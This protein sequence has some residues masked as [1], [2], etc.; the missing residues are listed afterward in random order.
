MPIDVVCPQCRKTL[1][2]GD[3]VAGKKIRCPACQGVASVPDSQEPDRDDHDR[4]DD[5]KTRSV[6]ANREP[7]RRP[8]SEPS[9]ADE[10]PDD[11]FDSYGQDAAMPPNPRV[12]GRKS[13]DNPVK[14]SKANPLL[15]KHWIEAMS[16]SAIG[17]AWCGLMGLAA[18]FLV[19][20]SDVIDLD[21][22]KDFGFG[23]LVFSGTLLVATCIQIPKIIPLLYVSMILVGVIGAILSMSI[24]AGEWLMIVSSVACFISLHRLRSVI[25]L[26]H[27]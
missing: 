23:M 1:R 15:R 18:I 20:E 3:H 19:E 26:L 17:A 13:K 9:A 25:K 12:R 21:K 24:I 4:Q 7:S 11:C 16:A 22:I 10:F 27:E 14:E 8:K 5:R 6:K 2:V